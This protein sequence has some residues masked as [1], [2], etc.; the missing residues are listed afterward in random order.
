MRVTFSGLGAGLYFILEKAF[1]GVDPMLKVSEYML[2]CILIELFFHKFPVM[3]IKSSLMKAQAKKD[4]ISKK[5]TALSQEIVWLMI[6][7][8][9]TG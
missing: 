5:D 3:D 7:I 6:N 1:P 2:Y 9:S 8:H 4:H